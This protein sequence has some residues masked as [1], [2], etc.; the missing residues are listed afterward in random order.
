MKTSILIGNL[1][2]SIR[3]ATYLCCLASSGGLG[4]L[5]LSANPAPGFIK[6]VKA[7]GIHLFRGTRS[8]TF[9]PVFKIVI[10]L[11][12]AFNNNLILRLAQTSA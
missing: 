6:I 8:K 7:G 3:T 10:L 4:F 5:T 11:I 12:G 1:I 9:Q 2:F